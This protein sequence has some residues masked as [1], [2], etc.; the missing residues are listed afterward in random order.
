[1]EW[2]KRGKPHSST[3]RSEGYNDERNSKHCHNNHRYAQRSG[4]P[5]CRAEPCQL[6]H[7]GTNQAQQFEATWHRQSQLLC[8]QR[9]R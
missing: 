6:N 3:N 7:I 1:M 4:K 9:D 5:T 8:E 2:N